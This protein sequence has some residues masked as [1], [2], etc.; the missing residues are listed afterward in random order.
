MAQSID[1]I[2]LANRAKENPEAIQEFFNV[3]GVEYPCKRGRPKKY[4]TP[5]EA[6]NAKR[7]HN[8]INYRIRKI[9]PHPPLKILPVSNNQ[10][11][12]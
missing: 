3:I 9:Q 8:A 2:D 12:E 7:I 11:S 5:E 4:S 1:L 10:P 6:R